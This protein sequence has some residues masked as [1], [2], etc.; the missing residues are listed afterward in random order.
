MAYGGN[1][2]RDRNFRGGGSRGGGNFRRFPTQ[3][4]KINC[5]D[6]GKESEVPF[7]P[8]EDRPVYCKECFIKRKDAEREGK[9]MPEAEKKEAKSE[10]KVKKPAAKEKV[11]ENEEVKELE[12]D[13][14]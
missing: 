13:L 14:Q 9:P 1:F 10:E 2:N 7:K 11:E 8:K 12:E 5:S 4:H 6:C 3:M